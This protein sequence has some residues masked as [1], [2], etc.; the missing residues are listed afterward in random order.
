MDNYTIIIL[1]AGASRRLGHAKQLLNVEGMPL[2]S[3]MITQAIKTKARRVFVVLGANAE[4]I[5][6]TVVNDEV[7]WVENSNWKEGMSSS[8]RSGINHLIKHHPEVEA[9]VLMMCDQPFVTTGLIN[10]IIEKQMQSGKDI[11]TCSYGGV[12]GPPTLFTFK[13]FPELLKLKGDA[14]A[15]KIIERS[16]DQVATV[17]FPR[18]E[19]DIDTESDYQ[20]WL[21]ASSLP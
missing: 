11:V 20:H 17:D 4:A 21:S 8:I 7:E 14:G 10:Q 2:L 18:G 19:I 5:R 3:Y 1:A 12:V 13:F 16:P 9:T 6:S 15:K